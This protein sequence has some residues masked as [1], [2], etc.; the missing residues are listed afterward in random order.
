VEPMQIE[1]L[2]SGSGIQHEHC[3]PQYSHNSSVGPGPSSTPLVPGQLGRNMWVIIERVLSGC[4][5]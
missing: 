5:E 3:N 4:A 2:P 1:S